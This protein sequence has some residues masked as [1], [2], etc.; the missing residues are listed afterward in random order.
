MDSN[1]KRIAKNTLFLYL[2]MGLLMFISLF[3]SRVLLDKLGV[4]DFGVYNVIGG[5]AAMFTF[6]SSSLANATQRFLNI[7]LGQNNIAKAKQI[8]QQHFTLYLVIIIA[9]IIIAEP[10][11]IWL[12]YNKLVIPADRLIAAVWV[13]QFTLLSLAA[14]FIGIVYNSEIVS[15]EDILLYRYYRGSS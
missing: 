13:F 12:I 14:T 7:E 9:V 3:T 15:H 11:G 10:I 8:F 1:S 6:F 5:M 4:E 2:R